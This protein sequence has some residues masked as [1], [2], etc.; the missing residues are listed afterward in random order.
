MMRRRRTRSSGR[1]GGIHFRFARRSRRRSHAF[2]LRND[3]ETRAAR[4]RQTRIQPAMVEE[5]A[6]C[7]SPPL[8]PPV[9]SL[10]SQSHSSVK[11]FVLLSVGAPTLFYYFHASEG[12]MLLHSQKRGTLLS[13]SL[14]GEGREEDVGDGV[15]GQVWRPR[16]ERE[17]ESAAS[18]L[19]SL[20]TEESIAL[21]RPSAS[22]RWLETLRSLRFFSS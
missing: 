15:E 13:R 14:S 1:A 22:V 9:R 17:R 7:N 4:Q 10:H 12:G 3:A 16:G 11:P 6:P 20:S 2:E 8:A 18:A 5:R 21:P 19:G